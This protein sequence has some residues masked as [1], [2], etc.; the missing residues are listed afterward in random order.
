ME[1][2]KKNKFVLEKKIILTMFSIL[3]FILFLFTKIELVSAFFLIEASLLMGFFAYIIFDSKDRFNPFSFFLLS[4]F[5][6][7]LDIVLVVMDIRIVN[8][9]YDIDIYEKSLFF[10]IIWLV[11]F[12]IGYIFKI[13]REKKI[14]L[15]K[16]RFL[17]DVIN[18]VN[19]DMML[20]IG[21]LF[22][23]FISYK[24]FSTIVAVGGI[25][26]AMNNFAV[27]RYNNQGYLATILPLISIVT[28]VLLE[29]KRKATSI[30]SMI[31]NF[32]LVTLTG[33]RGLAI[34][35]VII[36]FLIYYNY[37]IK[38][39]TNK[40]VSIVCIPIIIFILLI[41]SIRN[42][43][44]KLSENNTSI[45]N[46]IASVTNTIQYGQN[47]PDLINKMDNGGLEFQG[48]KN[49][50]NGITGLIPRSIWANKPE[51]D[52]SL[53]T[54]RLVYYD[55]I[56]YGKPVGAFGF[57]Y[58]NMGYIGIILSGIICGK[59]TNC[60]YTWVVNNKSGMSILLYSI[61]IQS[62]I[63]I[64]NPES[65]LKI[66]TLFGVITVL[67]IIANTKRRKKEFYEKD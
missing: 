39:I 11:S 67:C 23:F 12:C 2:I 8:I 5:L 53:I 50:L 52:H 51:S 46:I 47:V 29:K 7:F 19:M 6:G 14:R 63:I 31:Y 30:M 42:Q 9:K 37:R 25:S 10:I 60:F 54:S 35:T 56:T 33:R 32:V 13:K 64:T 49:L 38:K 4:L 3:F 27:F 36:P 62:V 16:I 15:K 24:I 43:T 20:I 40:E 41:G 44:V 34:N 26:T 48:T 22:Q 66:I 28:I 18:M 65:Q 59:I 1:Q 55:K 58:L 21:V 45:L 17:N 57:A 61:L